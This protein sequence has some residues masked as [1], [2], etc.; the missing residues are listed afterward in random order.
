MSGFHADGYE[1]SDVVVSKL[2]LAIAIP[3]IVIALGIVAVDQFQIIL[4]EKEYYNQ[5][6]NID[7]PSSKIQRQKEMQILQNY[8]V[9]DA[10]QDKYRLPITRAMEL[11]VQEQN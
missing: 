5:V 6:L 7:E 3:T 2:W 1:K 10:K 11:L 4:F 9:I 8:G